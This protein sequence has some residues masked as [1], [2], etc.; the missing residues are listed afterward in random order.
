M[1]FTPVR[2]CNDIDERRQLSFLKA[3]M[4][5][6]RRN[7]YLGYKK[8]DDLRKRV[9]KCNAMRFARNATSTAIPM[10]RP[11]ARRALVTSLE[12]AFDACTVD[13]QS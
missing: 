8:V 13:A 12:D 11:F 6:Q 1:F 2:Q 10:H 7:R 4:A 3:K 5:Q 9:L